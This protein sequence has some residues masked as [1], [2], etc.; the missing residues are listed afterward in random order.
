[1]LD[2]WTLCPQLV[3]LFVGRWTLFFSYVF[4]LFLN[5]KK[6]MQLE[7]EGPT[8][9]L[10]YMSVTYSEHTTAHISLGLPDT[11]WLKVMR[12]FWTK[13]HTFLFCIYSRSTRLSVSFFL[14]F[15]VLPWSSGT[16][17]RNFRRKSQLTHPTHP[18]HPTH[19]HAFEYGKNP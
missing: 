14:L 15:I 11:I 12:F 13:M 10:P 8:W 19:S 5:E 17:S 16:P 1:M 7:A 4:H 2:C 6:R 9:S 18:T 3:F